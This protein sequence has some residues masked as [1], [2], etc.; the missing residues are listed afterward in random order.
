LG[1]L[2][3]VSFLISSQRSRPTASIVSQSPFSDDR[4][5]T[6]PSRRATTRNC[7]QR[8]RAPLSTWAGVAAA[9]VV[10]VDEDTQKEF[11]EAAKTTIEGHLLRARVIDS[12]YRRYP[13]HPQRARYASCFVFRA[14]QILLVVDCRKYSFA[15]IDLAHGTAKSVNT[16]MAWLSG[17]RNLGQHL[18]DPINGPVLYQQLLEARWHA[19]A[20]VKVS[21]LSFAF[22]CVAVY[23]RGNRTRR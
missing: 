8:R 20:C 18:N 19:A 11:F 1:A 9:A 13:R 14:S 6:N 23:V 10:A 21:L 3:S 16:R 5:D 17:Y 4:R 12:F 15:L 7:R 22:S 2:I